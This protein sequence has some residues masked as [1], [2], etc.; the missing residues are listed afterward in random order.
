[1]GAS[2]PVT[3]K[4]TDT[5]FVLVSDNNTSYIYHNEDKDVGNE[6]WT[7]TGTSIGVIESFFAY[8]EMGGAFFAG[9]DDG[10]V[11]RFSRIGVS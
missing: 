11:Y 5:I 7:V 4:Y 9:S 3:D 8:N 10:A 6:F 1:M 2:A